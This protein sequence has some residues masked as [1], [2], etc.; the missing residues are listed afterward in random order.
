[1]VLV[2]KEV[3]SNNDSRYL[4]QS[5]SAYCM[6]FRIVGYCFQVWLFFWPDEFRLYNACISPKESYMPLDW[7][8]AG[9]GVMLYS[10]S[11]KKLAGL[12]IVFRKQS[13]DTGGRPIPEIFYFTLGPEHRRG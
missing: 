1:M 8:S 9:N 2:C 6:T 7:Y 13:S 11:Q 10:M 3:A 4:P 12:F 5:A